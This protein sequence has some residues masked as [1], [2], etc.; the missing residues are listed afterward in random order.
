MTIYDAGH[1]SFS[2]RNQQSFQDAESLSKVLS[3]EDFEP[4][5]D[6]MYHDHRINSDEDRNDLPEEIAFNPDDIPHLKAV[7]LAL[8]G[9]LAHG[10]TAHSKVQGLKIFKKVRVDLVA[11]EIFGYPVEYTDRMR[12]AGFEVRCFGS[13]EEY[14]ERAGDVAD[15]W[16]FYKPQFSKCGDL[17]SLRL[18]E[19]RSQ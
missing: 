11:P 12:E 18:N 2:G 17:T 3:E 8:V 10:R 15:V 16:Y 1:G 4:L 7:H 9:D 13:V 6:L 5:Q 14:L 19:L